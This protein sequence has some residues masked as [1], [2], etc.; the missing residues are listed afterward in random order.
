MSALNDSV[1][2][3]VS[4]EKETVGASSVQSSAK[5]NGREYVVVRLVADTDVHIEIGSNPTATTSSEFLPANTVEYKK[6]NS[7]DKIAHIQA[8]AGGSLYISEQK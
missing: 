2:M 3:T 7:G 5:S 6:I 8:S 4:T 1:M